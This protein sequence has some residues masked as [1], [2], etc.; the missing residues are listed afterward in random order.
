MASGFGNFCINRLPYWPTLWRWRG[1]IF[2]VALYLGLY[3]LYLLTRGLAFPNYST[4]LANG[5]RIASWE[6]SLAFFWE[7]GWQAWAIH[8]AKALVIFLNWAYIITY[9]PLVLV[10]AVLVYFV[11]RRVYYYYRNVIV[12]NL[13]IALVI[14]VLFPAAPPL[15]EPAY[16]VDTIK[17]FGPS[18]YEGPG[19]A[20][21]RNANAAMPSQHFS[22][23]VILGVLYLRTLKWKLKLLGLLYPTITFFAI[24]ITGN[25]YILDAVVGGLLAVVAFAVMELGLRRRFFLSWWWPPLRP[26]LA[27]IWLTSS[28]WVAGRRM[29]RASWRLTPEVLPGAGS[30]KKLRKAFARRGDGEVR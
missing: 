1:H 10:V 22:W 5:R 28:R 26:R 6:Q 11:N 8:H 29:R 14:F 15:R 3:L 24:T 17:V 23:T 2:E 25:H 20:A 27:S 9:F 19:V 4:A 21:Y 7:P 12:I 13:A 30:F 16:F 18:F